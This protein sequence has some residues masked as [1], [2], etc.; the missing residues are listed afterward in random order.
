MNKEFDEALQ[1]CLDL[2]RGGRETIDS[3]VA[4]YPEFAEELIKVSKHDFSAVISEN[5]DEV[6]QYFDE[7]T[8]RDFAKYYGAKPETLAIKE[9]KGALVDAIKKD[10]TEK[11][12]TPFFL[13]FSAAA[14]SSVPA[15]PKTCRVN[16]SR[17]S[18]FLGGSTNSSRDWC[19]TF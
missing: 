3:V 2:I 6:A 19:L 8:I 14:G 15:V 10:L 4:L 11:I 9:N 18:I 5:L 1:I 16:F 17:F 12:M 13:G 7:S